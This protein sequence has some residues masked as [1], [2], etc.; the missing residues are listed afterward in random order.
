MTLSVLQFVQEVRGGWHVCAAYLDGALE[1]SWEFCPLVDWPKVGTGYPDPRRA[2]CALEEAREIAHGK[3]VRPMLYVPRKFEEWRLG[4]C[5]NEP[6]PARLPR[7]K[8][9]EYPEEYLRDSP[10]ERVWPQR[11]ADL[12]AAECFVEGWEE[13][14]EHLAAMIA[15]CEGGR[16]WAP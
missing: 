11:L 16:P 9:V 2:A 8:A 5:K 3:I 14:P 10:D 4:R 6:D 15:A 12:E 7:G 1:A 13:P